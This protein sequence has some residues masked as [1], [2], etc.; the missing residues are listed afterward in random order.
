VGVALRYGVK[1]ALLHF[2]AIAQRIYEFGL[3]LKHLLV[4]MPLCCHQSGLWLFVS[5]RINP[6][7]L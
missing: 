3:I 5:K 2:A 7:I 6:A 4:A 1:D